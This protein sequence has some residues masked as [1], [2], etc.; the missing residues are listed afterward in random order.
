MFPRKNILSSLPD[1]RAETML[2][3][4]KQNVIVF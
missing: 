1:G 2:N 4:R 3:N